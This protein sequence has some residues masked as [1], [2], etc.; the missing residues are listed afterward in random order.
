MQLPALRVVG[1][2]IVWDRLIRILKILDKFNG[3]LNIGIG[4][5]PVLGLI[6][7]LFFYSL[8]WCWVLFL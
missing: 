8:V 1:V 2:L 4:E 5:A 3:I 6:V 7:W